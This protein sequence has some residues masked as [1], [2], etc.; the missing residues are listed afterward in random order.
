MAEWLVENGIGEQRAIRLE[1]GCAAAARIH[2]PGSLTAGQVSDAVLVSKPAGRTRG[3]ARFENGEEALVDRLPSAAQEGA[4][5]RL[6]VTRSK[7]S[8]TGRNKHAQARPT[9]QQPCTAPSLIDSLL[10][11]G[12]IARQVHRFPG[13]EWQEIWHEAWSGTTEFSGG[14]LQ[15]SAT[16]AMTLVDVDGS[17]SPHDLALAAVAPLAGAVQRFD[18]AGSL[19]IDFPT[20]AAKA[21]RRAVD[22]ALEAALANWPHERTAMNGFGFVQLLSRLERPS[23]LH[24]IGQHRVG[25]AARLLLRQAEAVHEPGKLL[26]TCH[27]GVKAKLKPAWLDELA[28]R[29]GREVAVTSDPGLALSAGF[30]QSV[31]A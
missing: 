29:T 7:M 21:E 10:S 22:N 12:A 4:T 26:L 16:P 14:S 18:L 2:W 6:L 3:L 30:A 13:S 8:E 17:L 5:L 31:P 11:A 15:F 9:E 19:G 28:R 23:L 1:G 25:A 20:L 24:R 27:P